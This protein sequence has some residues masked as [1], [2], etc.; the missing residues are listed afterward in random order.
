MIYNLI[1]TFPLLFFTRRK[2]RL[3]GIESETNDETWMS[4]GSFG[5]PNV[6]L[7]V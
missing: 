6:H 4:R 2:L 7:D 3:P 1:K 5:L